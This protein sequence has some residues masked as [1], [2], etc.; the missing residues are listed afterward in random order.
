MLEVDVL[1]LA[2]LC[3][4]SAVQTHNMGIVELLSN[5]DRVRTLQDGADATEARVQT[6][7]T[8]SAA[9]AYIGGDSGVD[10]RCEVL[11]KMSSL[12]PVQCR[13]RC[14]TQIDSILGRR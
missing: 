11:Q 13:C 7:Q 10:V 4:S 2:D 3:N 9:F 14:L 6:A 12:R 8:H 5:S 1:P